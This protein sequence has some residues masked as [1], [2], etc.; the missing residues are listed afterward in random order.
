M[1]INRELVLST[2]HVPNTTGIFLDEKV[3]WNY[4]TDD[5]NWRLHVNCVLLR[6]EI[7]FHAELKNLLKLAASHNCKWLV[8]DSDGDEIESYPTFEW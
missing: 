1:E 6:D 4:S 5:C 7:N 8:L 3:D 2:A